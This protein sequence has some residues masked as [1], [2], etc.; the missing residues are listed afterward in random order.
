L[1]FRVSGF[2]FQVQGSGSQVSGFGFPISGFRFRKGPVVRRVQ[3]SG[4]TNFGFR[5]SRWEEDEVG[6]FGIKLWRRFRFWF[7]GLGLRFRVQG[8]V[9]FP[10]SGSGFW[11]SVFGFQ[12]LD[13]G[14]RVSGL[15]EVKDIARV[16]DQMSPCRCST[17][18]C[19]EER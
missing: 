5:V 16:G 15:E 14:L 9:A 2:R 4:F 18:P 1:E 19:A 11:V 3:L 10:V 8:L 12:V 13:F 7:Q 6:G 17:Q